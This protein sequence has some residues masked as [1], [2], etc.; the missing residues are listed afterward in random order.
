MMMLS[1]S[2]APIVTGKG[3]EGYVALTFDDGPDEETTPMILDTLRRFNVPAAFFLQGSKVKN[4]LAALK[5]TIHRMF[6]DGHFVGSHTMS[7]SDLA[8]LKLSGL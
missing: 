2:K 4:A 3:Q 5:D 6:E 1:D 8:T 7:H